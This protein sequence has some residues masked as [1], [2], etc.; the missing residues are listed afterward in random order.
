MLLSCSRKSQIPAL[1]GI[2]LFTPEIHRAIARI[3]PSRRGELEITDAIQKLL[4]S[5]RGIRSHVHQGWWLDIG[6]R[7]AFINANQVILD[8]YARRDIKGEVD[9]KTRLI[10]RVEI[11]QGTKIENSLIKGPASIAEGCRITDSSIGPF[12]SIGAGTE[13]K[14]SS[15]ERSVILE[16]CQ[17]FNIKRLVDSAIDKHTELIK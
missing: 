8:D 17:I 6:D 7:D 5:G 9:S 14:N 12:T 10:G 13:V 3:K 2:Y 11:G 16:K 4:E 1:V 15:I